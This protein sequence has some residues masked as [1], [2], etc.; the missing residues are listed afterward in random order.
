MKKFFFN[1][2]S[3]F[4]GAWIALVLFTAVA[5]VLVFALI[6]SLSAGGSSTSITDK[7]VL[8]LNLEGEI[9][10]SEPDVSPLEMLQLVGTGRDTRQTLSTIE[11][12]LAE[13]AADKHIKAL[14]IKCKGASVSPATANAIRNAVVKFKKSKKPIY[15]YGAFYTQSDYYVATAADSIFLNPEGMVDLHGVYGVTPYF[16]GL[17]DKVGISFEIFRVGTYKSAVE[18]FML[19]EMSAPAR[20]Q[21]DTLYTEMWTTLRQSIASARKVTPAAVDSLINR[22]YVTLRPSEFVMKARLVDALCYE[23]TI[24]DRIASALGTEKKKISYVSTSEM[25]SASSVSSLGSASSKNQVA[26]LYAVGDIADGAKDGI[27]YEAIVPIVTELAEDDN[28]KALVLRVN[29]PGG[30]AFGSEQIW[31]ALEAFKKTGKPYAVSM[32]DYAA[33]GGYY[34]SCGADRIFAD[35]L[36]LTGSIG[37]FGMFPQVQGLV[38]GK[39]GVNMEL[40]A[41]NPAAVFPNP[42]APIT[43]PQRAAMQAYIE[44]GY[45]LFTSRCAAGR[46]M[47]VARIRQI[48]EGRVWSGTHAKQIG[49]VDELGGLDAAIEWV[50]K[51]AKLDDNYTRV[52]YPQND[53]TWR[54]IMRQMESDGAAALL[55]RN[56]G[57]GG[58]NDATASIVLRLIGRSPVQARMQPMILN[59]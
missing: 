13:G 59:L 56:Y 37:I 54:T 18:P 8:V 45:A 15:A 46:K 33:S 23:R 42:F 50:A 22:D 21:L 49:L 35:P 3:S 38:S 30:S 48:A 25:A 5:V 34:I 53:A 32:G 2:L 27:N 26:V 52:N 41:T 31:E 14:Y 29:S 55:M 36:T 4:V 44:H 16:K 57:I 6:G 9:D 28:V 24:D 51:K 10:E 47:S 40:V 58:L 39:L 43:E 12:A 1:L 19:T 11:T 17:L 20:A 7:S